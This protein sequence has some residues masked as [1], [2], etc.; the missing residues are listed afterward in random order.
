MCPASGCG[1]SAT[2]TAQ[3]LA[4]TEG[5]TFPF[6]APDGRAVAFFAA[7]E[8][9][10]IEVG[11]G[12]PQT[13]ASAPSGRGGA[14]HADGFIVFAPNLTTPLMRV[15]ATGGAAVTDHDP[16]SA[17]NQSPLAAPAPR[18]P[19]VSVLRTGGAGWGWDSPGRI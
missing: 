17:A 11:G 6:W 16:R 5:A 18:R 7:S 15:S 14:W 3:P 12:V 10:R 4:G 19:P 1:H 2:T 9:K 8:L 13:L